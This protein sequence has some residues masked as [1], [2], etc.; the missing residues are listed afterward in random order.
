MRKARTMLCL[1]NAKK[2]IAHD[3]HVKQKN[4]TSRHE[5]NFKIK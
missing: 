1:V 4:A 2:H 3:K 5:T